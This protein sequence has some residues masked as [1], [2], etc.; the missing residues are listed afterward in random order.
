LTRTASPRDPSRVRGIIIGAGRGRRLMPTTADAP[1][2]FAEIGDRR[3][4]DW[5]LSA[6]R[7]A[8]VD[9]ITFVGGY[10]IG[11]VRAGYPT[12]DFIENP[13]WERTNILGSLMCAESRM[14][15]GFVSS[16][17]DIVYRAEGIKRLMASRD[18]ITL[19]VDTAWRARYA[20]R[21]QHPPTDG[22]KVIVADGVVQ[23]IHRDI[24]PDRAYGEFIGVAKFT[25]QG[26]AMLRAAW[27]DHSARS[28]DGPF[29]GATPIGNAY[30]IQLLQ[31]MIE[32]GVSISHVDIDGGYHEI[33]T[34]EDYDL[35]R[36]AHAAGERWG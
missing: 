15:N 4:L 34:Q 29:R 6:L 21:S 8:G 28:G 32:E 23:R 13:Q 18:P 22:E 30:L 12:L 10:R 25:V 31:Q 24:D 26:A 17:A 20:P 3:I 33:D 36:A 9:P 11:D 2:C 16:Y 35:A 5:I 7:R 1:K 27:A 14:E 19:L